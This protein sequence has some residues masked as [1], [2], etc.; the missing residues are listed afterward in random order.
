MEQNLQ[1]PNINLKTVPTPS[2]VSVGQS[3]QMIL[4]PPCF[5][6]T[7][8]GGGALTE[9]SISSTMTTLPVGIG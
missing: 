9:L 5:H 8:A 6:S 4:Y 1:Q 7:E 2:L 3:R